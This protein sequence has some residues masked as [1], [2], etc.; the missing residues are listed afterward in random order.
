MRQLRQVADIIDQ[1]VERRAGVLLDMRNQV[2]NRAETGGND[3]AE[4]PFRHARHI[5]APHRRRQRLLERAA[6]A[7][8][9]VHALHNRRIVQFQRDILL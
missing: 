7:F 8:H 3:A 1:R 5:L 9:L 6:G 4:L 2:G